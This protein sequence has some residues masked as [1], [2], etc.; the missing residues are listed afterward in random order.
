MSTKN[1]MHYFNLAG[2]ITMHD[3]P[4]R[5]VAIA[6]KPGA[7]D[8][9]VVEKPNNHYRGIGDVVGDF[10]MVRKVAHVLACHH[11]DGIQT[12]SRIT[13]QRSLMPVIGAALDIQIS[14]VHLPEVP[15]A[16]HTPATFRGMPGWPFLA[17][18]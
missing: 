5:V 13:R 2:E 4:S 7:W 17:N 6:G 8:V 9:A 10:D 12:V 18:Q 11:V 1:T 3:C 15:I 16:A 14:D